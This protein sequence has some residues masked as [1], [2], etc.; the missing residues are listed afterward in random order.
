MACLLTLI[1]HPFEVSITPEELTVP[2]IPAIDIIVSDGLGAELVNDDFPV[3][4]ECIVLLLDVVIG[5]SIDMVI[6][7]P[8]MLAR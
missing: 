1:L 8:S 3:V 5:M 2:F 7:I 4:D 6:D